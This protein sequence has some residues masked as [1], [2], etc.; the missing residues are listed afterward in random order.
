MTDADSSN[1]HAK[2]SSLENCIY[3]KRI[4]NEPKLHLAA[5]N[6]NI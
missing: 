4:P 2:Y 1:V 3:C 6:L 5:I